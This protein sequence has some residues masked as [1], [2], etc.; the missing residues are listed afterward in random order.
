MKSG[1]VSYERGEI[2]EPTGWGLGVTQQKLGLV[3]RSCW[4]NKFRVYSRGIAG[5]DFLREPPYLAIGAK[6]EALAPLLLS[7]LWCLDPILKFR[8]CRIGYHFRCLNTN[9]KTNYANRDNSRDECIK[10]H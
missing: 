1:G 5:L 10:P 7:F 4:P 8:R 9:N 6:V 2:A 3:E